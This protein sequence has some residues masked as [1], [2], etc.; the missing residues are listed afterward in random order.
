MKIWK[1]AWK[2][3]RNIFLWIVILHI[4][5]LVEILIE[6]RVPYRKAI[7]PEEISKYDEYII[8]RA[9]RSSSVNAWFKYGD[10]N[11]ETT[12]G[13]EIIL[14]DEEKLLVKISEYDYS[15]G[16][17]LLADYMGTE[18]IESSYHYKVTGEKRYEIEKYKVLKWKI[19]APVVRTKH[20][21]NEN[22]TTL[23]PFFYPKN[24]IS[25]R[26]KYTFRFGDDI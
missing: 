13:K 26:D 22:L 20:N 24:Y 9:E 10:E 5:T 11:G 21:S 23:S 16:I 18:I 15:R 3:A 8:V 17:F 6:I 7:T 25:I 1:M 14:E 4:I 12:E 2:F 19:V